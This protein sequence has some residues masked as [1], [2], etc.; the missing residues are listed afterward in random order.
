MG[1]LVQLSRQRT[2]RRQS[3]N[4]RDD[5]ESRESAKSL[6]VLVAV[7]SGTAIAMSV[8]VII[9]ASN[10]WADVTLIASFVLVFALTKIVL[11]NALFYAMTRYDETREK[12][13]VKARPGA[14]FR[15]IP[16]PRYRKVATAAKQGRQTTGTSGPVRLAVLTRNQSPRA[17]RPH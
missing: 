3:Q 1:S 5:A 10:T 6:L 12:A 16:P 11:A 14:I 17:P 4:S 2:V 9:A 8:A 13:V 7:F 15:R